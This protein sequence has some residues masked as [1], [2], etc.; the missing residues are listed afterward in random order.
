MTALAA[1]LAAYDNDT[2]PF[3][4]SQNDPTRDALVRAV[5]KHLGMD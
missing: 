2:G 5:E 4:H 3:P 1:A